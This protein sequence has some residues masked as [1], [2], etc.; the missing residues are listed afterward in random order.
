MSDFSR[1]HNDY[2]DPDKYNGGQEEQ[3]A[4]EELVQDYIRDV[5][6]A[7]LAED[8]LVNSDYLAGMLTEVI[9]RQ[10]MNL[11]KAITAS[12]SDWQAKIHGQ[13]ELL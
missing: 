3:A 10:D 8:H 2:L 1:A 5:W 6:L 11:V 13:Q 12:A 7:E 9:G 4:I